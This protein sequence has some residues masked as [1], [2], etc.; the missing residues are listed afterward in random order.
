MI[1]LKAADSVWIHCLR[2]GARL[3]VSEVVA[4]ESGHTSRIRPD[5]ATAAH[6]DTYA[7]AILQDWG[8]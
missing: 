8:L 5:A 2:N 3:Q 1:H 7:T 6:L 4:T